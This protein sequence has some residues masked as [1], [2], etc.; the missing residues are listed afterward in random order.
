MESVTATALLDLAYWSQALQRYEY[1]RRRHDKTYAAVVVGFIGLSVCLIQESIQWTWFAFFAVTLT[2]F[3]VPVWQR[4]TRSSTQAAEK[5]LS[6]HPLR[7]KDA[8]WQF[9][10]DAVLLR[11]A[12]K[13]SLESWMSIR[14]SWSM[15]D[16]S[17]LS[18]KGSYHWLPKTA[19]TSEADYN[20]FLDL[21]AAKT[22]H[23][24]LS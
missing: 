24:K 22:K 2:I 12:D 13:E 10:D 7:D 23:S 4:S 1:V 20:R 9:A 6:S 17:I 19:F 16:G 11:V 5:K 21:L 18:F 8:I 15:A 3:F 14:G